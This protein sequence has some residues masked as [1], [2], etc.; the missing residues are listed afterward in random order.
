MKK[1]L[2]VITGPTGVGKTNLSIDLAKLYRGE[3]ISADSMQI[4]KYMDI[5]TAKIKETE[6]E[7]IPH[8]M[9]DIVEP[10]KEFTVSNYRDL[11]KENI[12]KVHKKSKLPIVVGGTGLYINSLVYDLQFASVPPNQELRNHYEKVA[13]EKGN[14][15]L[16]KTLY[17]I[18]KTS[19]E[20]ISIG[21]LKRIIRALEIYELTG[22]TMSQ[23]N[24][25]FRKESKDYNLCMYCLTMDRSRLYERINLRVD[26][27]IEEGLVEEVK[28][29][30]ERGYDP[31]LISL[32]GI[33]YK[34]IILYL[35]GN[36]SLDDSVEI[37]KKASRNYAKRQLTWFRRDKRFN[38]VDIDNF[39]TYNDLV[40][41]LTESIN[42]ILY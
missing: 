27:M 15:Y 28:S 35:K 22:K 36:I 16:H 21:D 38:W 33:G 12:L 1:N 19:A 2:L 34:E 3:I 32:Q 37:I 40:K 31:N 26:R 10:D 9:I 11:A 14:D 4:Y 39:K 20:K 7:D 23:Y 30:L 24:K 18:D 5:G 17:A 42:F 25:N 6:M 8:Y 41:Y 29:L 13:E